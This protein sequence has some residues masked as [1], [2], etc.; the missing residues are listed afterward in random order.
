MCGIVGILKKN[1]DCSS[2][3]LQ[4]MLIAINHRGPDGEG[5]FLNNNI[6]IGHKRLSIIDLQTGSQP[7][8]D[9]DGKIWITFNGEI[10]NFKQLKEILIKE[11]FFFKT[12]SDTEVIINAYKRWGVN[13]LE[14]FRGM[15]AFCIIDLNK[16]IAFL[17][18]DIFG[19]KPLVYRVDKN[20]FAFS[21]E[22]NALKSIGE[23]NSLTGEIL[24]MEYFLRYQ[25]I[26]APNTIYKN[27]FKLEQGHYLLVNFEGEVLKN[28]A[29]FDFNDQANKT[30]TLL[31]SENWEDVVEK[32]LEE[33]VKTHLVADVPFGIFLSGGI[34]STII[35]RYLRKATN[36]TIKAFTISFNEQDHDE[37][38]YAKIVAKK[39]DFELIHEVVE[40]DSLSILSDL[41]NNHYGEPFGDSS[42]IPTYLLSKLA[43][44]H[45]PLVLSGDGGDEVFGGYYS[46]IKWMRNYPIH[47]IKNKIKNKDFSGLPR[48]IAGSSKNY[49]INNFNSN[50]LE[51]WMSQLLI[52][53]SETR[54]KIW[55][56]DFHYLIDEKCS[57]FN[58]SHTTAKLFDRFTYA[59]L[60]D[61]NTYLPYS[62]LAKVDIASMANGLEVR[63]PI[64][65][66]EIKKFIYNLPLKQ[67]HQ[68]HNNTFEGK[69]ILKKILKKDF[70]DDFVYR[71]KQGFNPPHKKW[72][73]ENNLGSKFFKEHI[74]DN[75][76]KLNLFL[77]F[78]EVE[79]ILTKHTEKNDYSGTLWQ[80]LVLSIWFE[81]NNITFN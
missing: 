24:S 16:K 14:K 70:N 29:Y 13:C 8:S 21:S 79:T 64:L 39:Y 75:K 2:F 26:P 4:E 10:Y 42:A 22:L 60:M 19:I 67:K 71:H 15:F 3:E 18:R 73:L 72:F 17:A 51:E 45:V 78:N 33:S 48:Y 28:E 54:K 55:K 50:T 30:N 43:R 25:Y 52:T 7:M 34:D 27:V 80:I 35:S 53:D 63:P 68:L 57:S 40:Q 31:Q 32:A 66:I 37:L 46:Y 62:V 1:G 9:A 20:F 41:I 74:L 12:N 56:K 81:K 76:N 47:Y 61:I 44:K 11:G 77:N 58:N 59:Q 65:D 36:S 5:V 38:K 6:G 69:Y 49:L 23:K